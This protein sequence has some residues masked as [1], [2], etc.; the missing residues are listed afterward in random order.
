[1]N[2]EFKTVKE[3]LRRAW[4]IFQFPVPYSL[5]SILFL[6]GCCVNHPTTQPREYLGQ[7]LTMDQVVDRINANNE[8]IP[9]LWSELAFNAA[10]VD[11]KETHR[12]SGEGV[13]LYRR[14]GD[15][16][17]VTKEVGNVIFDIGSNRH[18]FWLATGPQAGNTI[19]WGHYGDQV[20]GD[21]QKG[22]TS[23]PISP[24][25]VA[26]VLAV[27]TID[28]NFFEPPVPVM[29]FDADSDAY[30]FIW[31]IPAGDRWLAEREVWYDRQTLRPGRV[32]L[33]DANGRVIL[34]ATL[35]MY[36]QVQLD[37]KPK[38]DWPWIAGDYK[39]IFPDTGSTME[40][41][42]DPGGAM[43]HKGRIPSDASFAMPPIGNFDHAHQIVGQ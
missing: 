27:G 9:S 24:A 10:I 15:F 32:L 1:V 18:E 23:I 42:L 28:T 8:K 6:A 21:G 17:L 39:L 25:A 2:S 29:R 41:T 13:L 12:G 43:I 35:G 7:T 36:E 16:R 40:F 33:Y 3:K 31:E 26:Q 20:G 14:P 19:W 22:E 5:F 34:K 30:V 4:H 38:T 11:Q 37:G